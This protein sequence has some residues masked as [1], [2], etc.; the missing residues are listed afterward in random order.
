MMGR[1]DECSTQKIVDDPRYS[2]KGMLVV[3]EA[4]VQVVAFE[5]RAH[6]NCE[7]AFF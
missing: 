5:A 6:L 7:K 2:G 3:Q 1:C 4:S